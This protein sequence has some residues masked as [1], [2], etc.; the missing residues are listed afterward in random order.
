MAYSAVRGAVVHTR[1]L[2]RGTG[3]RG[4]TRQVNFEQKSKE[5]LARI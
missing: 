3:M 1:T 4:G 2:S 5:L